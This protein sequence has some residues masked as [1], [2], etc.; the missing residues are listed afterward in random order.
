MPDGVTKM[1]PSGEKLG[2]RKKEGTVESA[3]KFLPLVLKSA[4]VSTTAGPGAAFSSIF[5]TT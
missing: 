2:R 5:I 1:A 3:Y 4:A